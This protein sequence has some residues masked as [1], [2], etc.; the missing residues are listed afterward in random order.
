MRRGDDVNYE[1]LNEKGVIITVREDSC[2]RQIFDIEL[3]KDKAHFVAREEELTYLKPMPGVCCHNCG[4]T[5]T[6]DEYSGGES[7]CCGDYV[8]GEEDFVEDIP[9]D[10][11]IKDGF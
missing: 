1:P 5:V 2:K 7:W 8:C 3:F 4:R 10:L 6:E 9:N 11:Q